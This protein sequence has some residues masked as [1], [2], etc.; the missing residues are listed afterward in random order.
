MFV[1]IIEGRASNADAM[2]AAGE[3]WDRD[4]RPGSEGFLGTTGGVT[5]DGTAILVARFVDS[6]AAAA[7]QARPEQQAWFEA[8][9]T[10]MFDGGEPSYTNSDDVE[11][12][13]GGGSDEAGFV[14]IMQGTCSDRDGAKAFQ[15]ST[16]DRLRDARPDL[17][18]GLTIWHD[19]GRHFTDVNW[20]SSEDEARAGEAR[21]GET[22]ADDF[23]EFNRL[24]EV[25]RFIDL[26]PPNLVVQ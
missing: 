17:L 8:H 10:A 14:Q 22:M 25:D 13:F 9:G 6:A 18:G 3:A 23:A 11:E 24:F 15:A 16:A 7:N 5:D 21:M 1:Q 4:V 2:R 19:D 26:R 12:L 20:F